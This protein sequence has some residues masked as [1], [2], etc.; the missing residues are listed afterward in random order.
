GDGGT[1]DYRLSLVIVRN[2]QGVEKGS[3]DAP[4]LPTFHNGQL[5][6]PYVAQPRVDYAAATGYNGSITNGQNLPSSARDW[7]TFSGILI[8]GS[9]GAQGRL[10]VNYVGT[11]V[12]ASISGP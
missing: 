8:S 6:A 4:F 10:S 1:Q 11:N 9:I 3:M 12:H 7:G 2:D 5:G